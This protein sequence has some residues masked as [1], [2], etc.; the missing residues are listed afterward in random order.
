MQLLVAIDFP[1]NEKI[2]ILWKSMANVLF[3]MDWVIL[4]ERS[5]WD[6]MTSWIYLFY[7]ANVIIIGQFHF[8]NNLIY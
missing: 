7:V 4:L 8:D 6:H 5:F 2:Y 1:S 3:Y